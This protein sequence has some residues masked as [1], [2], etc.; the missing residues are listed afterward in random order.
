[1]KCLFVFF[2][3][4]FVGSNVFAMNGWVRD[5]TPRGNGDS[6][7]RALLEQY[8]TDDTVQALIHFYEV[9]R[10]NSRI[11]TGLWLAASTV[12]GIAFH[13]SNMDPQEPDAPDQVGAAYAGVFYFLLLLIIVPITLITFVNSFRFNKKQLKKR[14]DAYQAGKPVSRWIRDSAVFRKYFRKN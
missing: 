8:G 14:L 7:Q 3:S 2:I 12:T 10:R 6:Y 4:L 9:R 13:R 1:M 5:S 11:I